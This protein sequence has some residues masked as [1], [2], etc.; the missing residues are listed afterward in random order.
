MHGTLL[1]ETLVT[2]T[3]MAT[4]GAGVESAEL[5]FLRPLRADLAAADTVVSAPTKEG[6]GK[7]A[8]ALADAIRTGTGRRPRVVDDA[9][10]PAELGPGPVLVLGNLMDS[11]LARELYFRA[12]D[13]TDACW[14]SPGGHVVRTVRNPFGTGAE[15]VM[16]G[17]SDVEGVASAGDELARIVGRGGPV[18]GYLNRVRLGEWASEIEG[19]TGKLL[20]PEFDGWERSGGA[21][22][23]NYQIAITKSAIGYL[24]TGD[25]AYLPVFR[26]E[27]HR[28]FDNDVAAIFDP[29]AR[30]PSMVHGFVHMMVTAWDLVRDHPSF[31]Q[32]ERR[33]IDGGFLELL[34]SREGPGRLGRPGKVVR[35]RDNHGTRTALDALFCGRYFK[36]RYGLDEADG[37]LEA[38]EQYFAPQMR[39]AKPVEDSWGHQWASSL[40]NT[41]IYAL[42]TGRRGFFDNA[43]F[44]QAAERALIAHG[45]LRAPVGYMCACAAAS[46]DMGFLSGWHD[47]EDMG[48]GMARGRG[49]GDEQLRSFFTGR[50]P[51]QREDLLGVSVAP[52]DQLW[53][54]TIDD[55]GFNPGGLFVATGP[56]DELFDKISIREG[57][58]RGAFYLLLDGISGGHHA[59]QDGNCIV[60]LHEK[61]TNWVRAGRSLDGTGSVRE[62]T[63]VFVAFEG[64]GPGSIHRYARK[65]YVRET[66][67]S[68]AVATA[69]EGLGDADWQRHVVRRQGRWTLVID[70]VAVRRP[71][72]VLAER[73]WRLIGDLRGDGDLL[74]VTQKAHGRPVHL[75]IQSAGVPLDGITD[76][77]E[78]VEK[79]RARVDVDRPVDFAAL[80]YAVDDAN[81]APYRLERAGE[82]W[83]VKADDEHYWVRLP[84]AGEPVETVTLDGS[85]PSDSLQGSPRAGPTLLSVHPEAPPVQ[86]PWLTVE[87]DDAV[88]AVAVG[89]DGRIALGEREGRVRLVSSAGAALFAATFESTVL[90]LHVWGE[91]LLVGEE[92]GALTC[93]DATGKQL[94][95]KAI[96]YVSMRWPY[97]SEHKSRI[98]EIDTADIDGDGVEEVLVS[99]SDRRVYAFSR[100]GRE[101]WKAPVEW[102]IWTALTSG[103]FRGGFGLYGGTSR[104]SIHGRCIVFGAKGERLAY[105]TRPDLVN[106]SV[107]CQFRDMRLADLDGDGEAE[108]V[109][110]IDTACRQLVVYK[111]DG[112]VLWD[113]DTAG[114]VRCVAVGEDAST[115][116]CG[117][118]SGYAYAFE[119]ASGA[120]RWSC[121][122]GERLGLV[123]PRTDGSV[124]AVADS[125]S[126][127][128]VTDGGR[129]AGRQALGS[130]ISAFIRPGDHR[131]RNDVLVGTEDGRVLHLARPRE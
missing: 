120:R 1:M 12:F 102:G 37:W 27:L 87:A 103:R 55:A 18:L 65:L 10:P 47:L 5:P 95:Q 88:T 89:P 48:R 67:A 97:W 117:G 38:A 45:R 70:R 69:Q 57:W 100:D 122:A 130:R 106:W 16:V 91:R 43:F 72:E 94:W 74:T 118:G 127:Y 49:L 114:E 125:G 81:D 92:R 41:V 6:Y 34:R 115:V 19:Y 93:L 63:G 31:T 76:T 105:L 78:R 112:S 15:V 75:K 82:A 42:A 58:A 83:C 9:V 44:R 24:R 26:R 53:Y 61:G 30:V 39:S 11:R 123:A 129:L 51:I 119:G 52:L 99:N 96:P 13:F 66:D 25:E 56:R 111:Q 40:Y 17:G 33:R 2:L 73:H 113:A 107:P 84:P 14:P 35:V 8:V 32:E 64:S 36:L 80:I 110:G 104:P 101:L 4:P 3:L 29:N 85:P 59:Y 126:V 46:G 20:D 128:V 108:A 98:R 68:V 79:V 124:V 86:L 109:T 116:Y 28:F 60:A 22:S 90:S 121:Y 77:S 21:G 71:G 54:D 131:A 62:Q 23:W 7:I 50:K